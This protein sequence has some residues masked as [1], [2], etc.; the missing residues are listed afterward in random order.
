MIDGCGPGGDAA[1]SVLGGK[2]VGIFLKEMEHDP[3]GHHNN[4]HTN[5]GPSGGPSSSSGYGGIGSGTPAT[6][7]H[8]GDLT[9]SG[10]ASVVHNIGTPGTI[11]LHLV[12]WETSDKN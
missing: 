5:Y 12:D 9:S 7:F 2:K 3:D 4:V 11:P 8:G 10:V 1:N 6:N